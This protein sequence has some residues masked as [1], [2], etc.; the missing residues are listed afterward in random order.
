MHKDVKIQFEAFLFDVFYVVA[1]DLIKGDGTSAVYLSQSRDSR[2]HLE[3]LAVPILVG[4]HLGRDV[5]SGSDETHVALDNIDDLGRFVQ[6]CFAQEASHTGD[7]TLPD[8]FEHVAPVGAGL[9]FAVYIG[10]QER[11]VGT[12]I[13]VFVH[14]AKLVASKGF[15]V[16]PDARL[17]EQCSPWRVPANRERDQ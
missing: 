9:D 12:P 15:S 11:G 8:G 1:H 6:T 17:A 5:W 16:F 4:F 3:P 10:R 14:R 2:Q 13:D 7:L